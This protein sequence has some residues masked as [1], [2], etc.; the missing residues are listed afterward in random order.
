[1]RDRGLS[2]CPSL[3]PYGTPY[4]GK[5]GSIQGA[6]NYLQQ[7][8]KG[9]IWRSNFLFFAIIFENSKKAFLAFFPLMFLKL[10]RS[11][12][13]SFDI[14]SAVSLRAPFFSTGKKVK[15]DVSSA[16]EICLSLSTLI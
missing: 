4:C 10:S 5:S 13:S 8:F 1:M 16:L 12:V 6:T 9:H 15:I 7:S 11:T 14:F 2:L 3:F